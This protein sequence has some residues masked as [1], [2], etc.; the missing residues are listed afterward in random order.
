[1]PPITRAEVQSW[2]EVLASEQTMGIF[3]VLGGKLDEDN[4]AR[5]ID[6]HLCKVHPVTFVFFVNEREFGSVC[7]VHLTIELE[8][9]ELYGSGSWRIKCRVWPQGL[10]LL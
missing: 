1:M 6:L 8:F 5:S 7:T 2:G 9:R 10:G 4:L 3:V